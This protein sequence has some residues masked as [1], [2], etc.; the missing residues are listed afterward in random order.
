MSGSHEMERARR[1]LALPDSWLEAKGDGYA[2]RTG[3]DRRARIMLTLDETSFRA[4]T[5]TPGLR[6]RPGGGWVA[7]QAP[8][9]LPSA[10]PAG[11]PGVTEGVRTVMLPDGQSEAR[12]ANVGASPVIWLA[13]RIGANGRPGLTRA[14]VAAAGRLALDAEALM[15]GGAVT[16]QWDAL[17][18]TGR[19][20]GR[21]SGRGGAGHDRALDAAGRIRAALTACGPAR[22]VVERVCL[23]G[24]S[25][26]STEQTLG[27]R[28][29]TARAILQAGLAALARHYRLG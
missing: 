20:G 13:A 10:P 26:Q 16:L 8:A 18:R 22:A 29:R 24:L 28:R 23:H 6:T 14:E 7:R 11:R 19:G 1:L 12:V 3:R 2:L 4:L 27:L 17:P 15:Q 21:G 25:L 5:L 9:A